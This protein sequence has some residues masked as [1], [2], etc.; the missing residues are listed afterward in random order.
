VALLTKTLAAEWAPSGVNVNAIAPTAV[1]TEMNAYLLD[2]PGFL[3]FFVPKVPAGRVGDP[4][5]VAGAAVFLAGDG[6]D[7]VHGHLLLVDGG[8]TAV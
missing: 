8:Y 1:R 5:D 6:S 2:D 7:F 3:E 4:S